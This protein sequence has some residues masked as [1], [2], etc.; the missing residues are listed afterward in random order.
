[1]KLIRCAL[2]IATSLVLP[3]CN[4]DVGPTAPLQSSPVVAGPW[5]GNVSYE[6]LV[7]FYEEAPCPDQPVTIQLQQ[8]DSRVSGTIQAECVTAQ[9][10]GTVQRNL[11]I[12]GR[13][14]Q[15]LDGQVYSANLTGSLVGSPVSQIEAGT[16]IFVN[17][18]GW[19]REAIHLRL[20]R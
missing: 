19:R 3:A 15:V 9:F 8:E 11:T 17:P 12:R 10:E 1:M 6:P 16:E 13:V 14:T 7:G 18:N 5:Q 2:L 20:T 4:D